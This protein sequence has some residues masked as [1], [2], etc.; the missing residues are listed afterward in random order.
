MKQV[1][2][3]ILHITTLT[4]LT[5]IARTVAA[6]LLNN[7]SNIAV[8]PE[9]NLLFPNICEK[10]DWLGRVFQQHTHPFQ[11]I[12]GVLYWTSKLSQQIYTVVFLGSK[13]AHSQLTD[14]GARFRKYR[15][16][17]GFTLFYYLLLFLNKATFRILFSA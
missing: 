14:G 11:N 7:I 2:N 1:R 12:R 9:M 3:L 6:I 17:P 4:S 13:R 5:E 16:I 8:T 15:P 10:L